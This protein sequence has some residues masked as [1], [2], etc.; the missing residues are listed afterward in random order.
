M[1]STKKPAAGEDGKRAADGT[2]SI[3][4]TD[5]SVFNIALEYL[6]SALSVVPIRCDGRKCPPMEWKIYCTQYATEDDLRRWFS[7]KQG[8]GIVCGEISGGLEVLDFDYG[9]LFAPWY[10]QV[11]HIACKLPI[12]ETPSDGYHV[13]Y[14]CEEIGHCK[15]I[16]TDPSLR[17]QGKKETLI[18]TRGEGGL[19]VACGSPLGVHDRKSRTYVQ[20]MGP[21]LPEI[22]HITPL[23][24]RELWVAARRF[25]KRPQK[26]QTQQPKRP[27]QRIET[28]DQFNS[29]PDWA[30]VLP[31]WTSRDGIHWTR[32]GKKYG[33]SAKTCTAQDGTPLL[34]IY[35][36]N[37][38]LEAQSYNAFELLVQNCFR[39]DRRAALQFIKEG[40]Q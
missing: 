30:S 33:C 9:H 8:I 14:R 17:A 5:D 11:S 16:A 36:T 34:T 18:E 25:D 4:R 2:C 37:A 32:P 15:K 28:I 23:E 35:S 19:I 7:Q 31:G 13:L 6:R 3:V 21:P 29:S 26:K 39:G 1:V 10:E 12:V 24:R 27:H 22:P 40:R 38:G 20:V